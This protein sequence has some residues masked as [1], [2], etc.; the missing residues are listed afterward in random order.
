MHAA[1]AASAQRCY[2]PAAKRYRLSGEATVEFCLDASGGLSSTKLA[3]SSGE[4]LLDDAARDC[5]IA[6]ALPFPKD[7]AGGCYSVP[8]RFGAR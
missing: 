7:A 8:V 5:V 1:L 2:P 4:N 6:G 3:S